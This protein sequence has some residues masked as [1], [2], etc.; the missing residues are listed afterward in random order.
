MDESEYKEKLAKYDLDDRKLCAFITNETGAIIKDKHLRGY[1]S[2]SRQLSEPM[3]G[4]LRF[5]FK[6]LEEVMS[7]VRP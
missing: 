1:F 5:A 4:L 2:R 3:T 7:H 6:R